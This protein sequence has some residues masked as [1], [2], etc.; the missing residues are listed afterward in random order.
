MKK[1]ACYENM[2]KFEIFL[3]TLKYIFVFVGLETT[4]TGYINFNL[5]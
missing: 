2:C 1:I 3:E 5:N 4:F